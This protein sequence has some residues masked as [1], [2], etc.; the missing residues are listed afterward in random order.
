MDEVARVRLQ[1]RAVLVVYRAEMARLS[2]RNVS[3]ATGEAF[4]SSLR[5]RSLHV[6]DNARAT[7]DGDAPEHKDLVREI[8]EARTEISAR[9]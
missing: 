3:A 9:A 6:L 8:E 4:A 2:R 7:L 5:T 1:I